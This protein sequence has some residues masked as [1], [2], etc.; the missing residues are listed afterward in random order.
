M[1]SFMKYAGWIIGASIVGLVILNA[2]GSTNI[3]NGLSKAQSNLILA[4]QGR[5]PTQ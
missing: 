5:N 1:A 4:L 3:I 2:S